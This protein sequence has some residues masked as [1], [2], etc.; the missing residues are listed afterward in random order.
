M[1]G[2]III[3]PKFKS[4]ALTLILNELSRPSKLEL[5]WYILKVKVKKNLTFQFKAVRGDI[6]MQMV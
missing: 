6:L 1:L 4:E 5:D 2:E 3:D